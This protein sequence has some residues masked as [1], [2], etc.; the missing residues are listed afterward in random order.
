MRVLS[1]KVMI[2]VSDM[3]RAVSFYSEVFDAKITLESSHFT[4]MLLGDQFTLALHLGN[5]RSERR[6]TGISLDVDDLREALARI[7]R[8][9]GSCIAGPQQIDDASGR[10]LYDV[11]DTEQNAFMLTGRE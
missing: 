7:R 8:S 4:E 1:G 5:G 2:Y 9:D 3:E 11:V 10:V 6:V